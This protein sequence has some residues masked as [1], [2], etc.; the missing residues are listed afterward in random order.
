MSRELL[1]AS[2]AKLW[3]WEKQLENFRDFG[4]ISK[5]PLLITCHLSFP[6]PIPIPGLSFSFL[7]L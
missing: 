7:I 4:F 6:N 3:G 5:L 1:A 2:A